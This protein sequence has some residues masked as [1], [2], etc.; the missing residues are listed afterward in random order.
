[1]N[2]ILLIKFEWILINS[3]YW[4]I[5]IL[6]VCDEIKIAIINIYL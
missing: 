2:E 1:M 3:F 4:L 5:R 6:T